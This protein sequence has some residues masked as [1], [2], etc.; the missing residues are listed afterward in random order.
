M[1]DFVARHQMVHMDH[2]ADVDEQVWALNDVVGQ[3]A[4]VFVDGETGQTQKVY[5]PLGVEGLQTAIDQLA[6]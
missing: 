5:G 1:N 2:V 6:R 4:W 3:P